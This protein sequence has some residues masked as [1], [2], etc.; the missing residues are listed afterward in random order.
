M[1]LIECGYVELFLQIYLS[2][3]ILGFLPGSL[4]RSPS[5]RAW[6][7]QFRG[8]LR[9]GLPNPNYVPIAPPTW[10]FSVVWGVL[11]S[12]MGVAAYLVREIGGPYVDDGN[13]WPL[14]LFWILQVVLAF[15]TLLF[16]SWRQRF[17][18]TLDI[19]LGLGLTITVGVLFWSFSVAAAILMFVTALWETFALVLSIWI[20][21]KRS[22]TK[23]FTTASK[24]ARNFPLK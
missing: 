12:C 3:V 4:S 6:Y 14:V 8:R 23:E 20:L 7:D 21:A 1:T 10:L 19:V 5:Q 2:V 24:I 11:Y 22:T 13:L 16:F 17:L 18:G 15:Y 9:K